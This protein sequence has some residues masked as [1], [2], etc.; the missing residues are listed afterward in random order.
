MQGRLQVAKEKGSAVLFSMTLQVLFSPSFN[1]EK[2][3]SPHAAMGPCMQAPMQ[4]PRQT[5]FQA[6][7]SCRIGF[8]SACLACTMRGSRGGGCS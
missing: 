6:V 3:G 8:G 1:L 4:L 5:A 2:E 7:W